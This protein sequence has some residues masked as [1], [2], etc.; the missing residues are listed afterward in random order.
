MENSKHQNLF[1][2]AQYVPSHLK[3]PLWHIAIA[4][5]FTRMHSPPSA[6]YSRK[7]NSQHVTSVGV[8]FLSK[9]LVKFF[10]ML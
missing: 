7:F 3:D 4:L 5:L 9:H 10:L 8:A 2:R 6:H 1:L